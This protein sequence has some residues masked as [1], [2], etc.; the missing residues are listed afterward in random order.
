MHMPT[1]EFIVVGN[2]V[3][4]GR[5]RFSKFGTYTPDK[6]R[7]YERAV[8]YSAREAMNGMKPIDAVVSMDLMIY[9]PIPASFSKIKHTKAING[10]LRPICKSDIDNCFK[11]VADA[12]NK[13][14]YVDDNR[15][16]DLSAHRFYS[17][18]PR[19]E[20]RVNWED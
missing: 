14:V 17:T 19:V 2:P 20:V 11:A 15:I 12:C 1:I 9:M 8:A 16:C 3:S 4:K 7:N 10:E 13:I 6:T 5:P 18:V